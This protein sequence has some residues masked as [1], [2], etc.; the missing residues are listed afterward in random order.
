MLKNK[1]KK[2]QLKIDNSSQLVLIYQSRNLIYMI[3]ITS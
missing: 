2:N 1:I 3:K